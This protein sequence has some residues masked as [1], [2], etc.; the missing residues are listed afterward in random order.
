MLLEIDPDTLQELPP[1]EKISYLKEKINS[2][3]KQ[4][5]K[6]HLDGESG[7]KNAQSR[8]RCIDQ[9]IIGLHQAFDPENESGLAIVANG[10]FG[11]GIM[12]PGS[13]IDLLFL[14]PTSSQKISKVDAS[15]IQS[16]QM[17]IWDLGFKFLPATRSIQESITE[18]KQEPISRTTL[19]DSRFII[20][21]E[22]LFEQFSTRFRKECITKDKAAFFEE[23][24]QD[25]RNR[26]AK[27]SHTVFLQEPNIK[28]SPAANKA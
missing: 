22:E 27:Y 9:L 3:E 4:L 2:A 7:L 28:E 12:N 23:R 10:G 26:H 18:A 5:H 19:L 13:D 14:T 20:G 16:I 1:E 8:S 6:R 11:R 25:I 17:L 21:N 15:L 24:S